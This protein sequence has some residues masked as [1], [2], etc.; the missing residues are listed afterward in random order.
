MRYET[1]KILRTSTDGK[2]YY[3]GTLYPLITPRNSD[4]YVI[5]T[6]GDRLD[7]LADQYYKDSKMWWIIASANNLRKDSLFITPGTQ[8]RIPIDL[9]S[10]NND[11]SK[12]NNK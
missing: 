1:S 7:I 12:I 9:V 6:V 3:N 5:T 2:R 8:L 4:I 11:M 10:F